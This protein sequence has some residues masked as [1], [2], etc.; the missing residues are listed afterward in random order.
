MED[1]LK[2]RYGGGCK[3]AE[4][5]D[6]VTVGLL[7]GWSSK[8]DSRDGQMMVPARGRGTE[9]QKAHEDGLSLSTQVNRK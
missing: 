8:C 6:S 1:K 4:Q 9:E 5:W 3:E 2:A 7:R